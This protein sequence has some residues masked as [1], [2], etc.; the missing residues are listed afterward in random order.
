[1]RQ[2]RYKTIMGTILTISSH[3]PFATE[4]AIGVKLLLFRPAVFPG[5][6]IWSCSPWLSGIACYC[7]TFLLSFLLPARGNF[8]DEA[9]FRHIRHKPRRVFASFQFN[10][11]PKLFCFLKPYD[12]LVERT[13]PVFYDFLNISGPGPSSS[14]FGSHDAQTRRS[15]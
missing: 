9:S 4:A 10:S 7:I 15:D 14:D 11:E 8:R 6:T 12:S 5:L 1:M 2:D 13:F 3:P